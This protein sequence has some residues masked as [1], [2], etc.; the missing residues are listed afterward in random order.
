MLH[1]LTVLSLILASFV[2]VSGE[3][4]FTRTRAPEG[5]HIQRRA[6]PTGMVNFIFALKQQHL[7][8][9]ESKFWSVSDPKSSEYQNFM[10][11][12]EVMSIIAPKAEDVTLV[13]E[14]LLLHG[15]KSS[16]I[17]PLGDALEVTTT[18]AV[19]ENLFQTQFFQYNNK[20]MKKTV[21]RQFGSYSLPSAIRSRVDLITGVTNFPPP[22]DARYGRKR[23][24]P[25]ADLGVVAQTIYSLYGIGTQTFGNATSTT[26][27]GVIEF[28]G[29][30][31]DK[32]DLQQ[33]ATLTGIKITPLSDD[34]IIGPEQDE[35][36]TEADLDIQFV[37]TVNTEATNWFWLEDPTAWLYGFATHFFNTTDV[38]LVISISYGWWEGDQCTIDPD[39]CQQLGVTDDQYTARVNTEFQ[40][41]GLRGVT[42]V[43]SSGDSGAH[44]RTDYECTAPTLRADFPGAS[45]YV[46]SVGATQITNASPLSTQPKIC[47]QFQA[48]GCAASG[49]E[50]AVSYQ[51]AGFTSGGGFSEVAVQPDYQASAVKSYLSS[52][53]ALPP[54]TMYN[55]S[56]R[57]HPDVAAVGH[58][59]L[60]YEGGVEAV[61]GTSQSAPT[62]AAILSLLNQASLSKSG[63]PIGFANPLLYT[64]WAAVPT[65]FTDI[66][67]GDNKCTE[68]GCATGCK[69]WLA[70]KGWDPVTG[71]GSLN[72][73][74]LQNYILSH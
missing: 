56:N 53:V 27:Q 48:A 37:A 55:A 70:A 41:I 22:S 73:P 69:G 44:T 51:V 49:T 71:L 24:V 42:M 1:T 16:E 74:V 46:T 52:G 40:K 61:G 45:P 54:A 19:A 6:A 32:E 5:W 63:K 20:A 12:E 31:Y 23:N 59:G 7:D 17:K 65:A 9:L 50:V 28:Q 29:Q 21:V 36:E 2:L 38:P 34:H 11:I 25:N 66:T 4:M 8:V 15:V 62:V 33:Y 60:I 57:A 47:T 43:V 58:N 13:T 26:S 18:V 67:V 10:S 72:Y 64:I 39:N 3:V 30:D 35:P 14:W 68:A